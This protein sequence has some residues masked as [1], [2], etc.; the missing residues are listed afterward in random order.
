MSCQRINPSR[1]TNIP[2][3]PIASRT[4]LG[5]C[6]TRADLQPSL[7]ARRPAFPA[8]L[9]ARGG[10]WSCHVALEGRTA[11]GSLRFSRDF[12]G[13]PVN[14]V[15][16]GPPITVGETQ[17]YRSCI[18]P[19]VPELGLDFGEGDTR[20]KQVHRRPVA[21]VQAAGRT[22]TGASLHDDAGVDGK[23]VDDAQDL[24]AGEVAL[25]GLT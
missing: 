2:R 24:L 16:D 17:V 22:R 21:E 10:R 18:H 12:E 8:P 23:P 20:P 19:G 7:L 13:L 14:P 15:G 5:A 3:R 6:P 4:R 11:Y 9:I 1:A 25:P